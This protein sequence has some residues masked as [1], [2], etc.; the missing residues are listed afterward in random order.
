MRQTLERRRIRGLRMRDERELAVG[1]LGCPWVGVSEGGVSGLES[2]R[3]EEQRRTCGRSGRSTS[4]SGKRSMSTVMARVS[5]GESSGE[6][7]LCVSPSLAD[8]SS[9][10]LSD[11]LT[12]SVKRLSTRAS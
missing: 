7:A 9:G 11:G 5:K 3:R 2:V 4:T 1:V 12:G 8:W 6:C 10:A